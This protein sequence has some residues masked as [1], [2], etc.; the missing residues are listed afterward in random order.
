MRCLI[1]NDLE[2]VLYGYIAHLKQ[3]FEHV[4]C[5]ENGLAAFEAVKSHPIDYYDFI[6][7]DVNMPIMN[8]PQACEAI[9]R[10]LREKTLKSLVTVTDS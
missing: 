10:Y 1:A 5:A 3:Y 8:G 9:S 4:D 6:F 2:F 7:L